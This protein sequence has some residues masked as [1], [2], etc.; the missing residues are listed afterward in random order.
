MQ[1]AHN[2]QM[3]RAFY[4]FSDSGKTQKALDQPALF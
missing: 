4:I 3:A 2:V 1:N